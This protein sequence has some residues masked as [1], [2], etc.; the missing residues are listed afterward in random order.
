M[1]TPYVLRCQLKMVQVVGSFGVSLWS[2][3]GLGFLGLE[4]GSRRLVSSVDDEA[5]RRR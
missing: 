2:D 1:K 3:F 5:F 4:F